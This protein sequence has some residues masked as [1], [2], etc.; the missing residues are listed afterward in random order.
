MRVTWWKN[1]LELS[2]G[3][4]YLKINN[5][6]DYALTINR[7]NIA[8]DRGEYIVRAENEFGTKEERFF[9]NVQSD[10]NHNL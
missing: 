4:K 7:L 8:Q 9:V 6:N 1:S 5:G 10:F 2:D 3:S